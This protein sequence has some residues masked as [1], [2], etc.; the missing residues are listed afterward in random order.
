MLR[1]AE[2]EE[3]VLS[4]PALVAEKVNETL[5]QQEYFI[6]TVLNT[7]EALV[8]VFDAMGRIVL[9][10]KAAEKLTGYVF[11][12]VKGKPFGDIF[13]LP[14]EKD[15]VV[16]LVKGLLDGKLSM[17]AELMN[18][19]VTR[20][21]Q[22]RLI[23]W[24]SSILKNSRGETQF[25]VST[26]KDVTEE[27]K[28]KKALQESEERYRILVEMSPDAI[29]IHR[30]G[31]IVYAN[32]ATARLLHVEKADDLTGM[33]IINLMHSDEKAEK[34]RKIKKLN[35]EA[36]S[37]K[38]SEEKIFRSDGSHVYVELIP[39]VLSYQG[40]QAIQV[41]MRDITE[42]KKMEQELLKV[43][44]LQ[45]IGT[46]AGSIAHE[47]NNILTVILG[48]LSVARLSANHDGKAA[49]LLLEVE[50]AALQAKELTQRLL[51]FARGG[52]P[53]KQ[54]IDLR[55]LLFKSATHVIRMD[56]ANCNLKIPG[57][58]YPVEADEGQLGHA[59]GNIVLNAIQAMQGGGTVQISAENSNLEDLGI[60]D[61]K[62]G[63]YV[64]ISISDEGPGIPRESLSDIFDPFYTTKPDGSG[65]GLSTAYSII[66]KHGG[67]LMVESTLGKGSTFMIYL[68]AVEM[69]GLDAER[70]LE[71]RG[72][73]QILLMDDEGP[74]RKSAAEMLTLLGYKVV[75]ASNGE[76]AVSH[77][78]TALQSGEP[79]DLVILDLL[80]NGGMGGRET[81]AVLVAE[82]PRVRAIVS[83]GYSNDPVMSDCASYG[84]SGCVPKPYTL[85]Q[86][87]MAVKRV[88][89][90]LSGL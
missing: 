23:A 6:S 82:D 64:K 5:H 79:F 52:Q 21:G 81:M 43:Q 37:H 46:L 18:H 25:V 90:Q 38:L 9:F 73:G 2:T 27:A 51:T 26:G 84:F 76:E 41:V 35:C 30:E 36:V 86:L 42:R 39:K 70:K 75:T 87:G 72:A 49:E 24:S 44:K 53:V 47:Y 7:I 3:Q 4:I 80:V 1:K 71:L 74:V 54:V 50:E 12:E 33:P 55:K 77:Y 16:E 67:H 58:L 29:F 68:P 11:D 65:L 62:E 13:L 20:N 89:N 10:N 28:A 48:N 61:Q 69:G 34:F 63:P 66:H 15:T 17:P 60:I 88:L 8:V 19:W 32:T 78:R 57:E 31:K 22:A 14:E 85:E 83:S 59:L 45:S 56:H 40:K